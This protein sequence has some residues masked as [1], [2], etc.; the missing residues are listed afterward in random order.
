[1]A[2]RSIGF[3]LTIGIVLT[4]L[5]LALAVGWQMLVT[6]DLSPV[7]R[8][9]TT[10]HWLLLILGTLFFALIV[11]GL[12][13][14]CAWL[15]REMRHNQRQQ[16]FL[17]AVTHE[18]R[19]PLA[20]LRLY[21]ETLQR[22]DPQPARRSEFL[23]RMGAD[24]DRLDH[25]VDQVLAAARAEERVRHREREP[26]ELRE[27]LA[28][29][30]TELRSRHALPDDAI[31]LVAPEPVG[32]QG[33][34][35][36]L[37][38]VFRNLL[39]NAVK[40]SAGPVDVQVTVTRPGDG[41]VHVEIADA[42]IGIPPRE[43]R[44]IFQRF[45]RAGRD[46]KRTAAGLGLGLFIVRGLVRRNGGRVIARSEGSGRGSRFVVTLRAALAA[47]SRR[48]LEVAPQLGSGS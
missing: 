10:V 24:L 46:V 6:S 15:I 38:V 7:A 30:A 4:L 39:D 34:A 44:K 25:T 2:R 5:A 27:L 11:I 23:G 33:V 31:R 35:A 16:A 43:I 3:P 47:S 29:V 9:L 26:L 22:H 8:G 19:T 42:G 40:Y 18:M 28:K 13:L 1:M 21:V 41:R 17:D 37:E 14:L 45:Y 12:V 32:A 36:E 20:S 48:A